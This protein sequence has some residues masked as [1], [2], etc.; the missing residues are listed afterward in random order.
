MVGGWR[1]E[2]RRE[3]NKADEEV[4]EEHAYFCSL[5]VQTL[6]QVSNALVHH[7]H[8]GVPL[9]QQLLVLSQFAA[10]FQVETIASLNFHPPKNKN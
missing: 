5:L 6:A 3:E 4:K 7:C 1:E 8:L 9:V 10:L 2:T